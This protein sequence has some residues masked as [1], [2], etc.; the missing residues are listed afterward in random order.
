MILPVTALYLIAAAL[1]G[2][3]NWEMFRNGYKTTRAWENKYAKD[4]KGVLIPAPDK[5]Y[6][7][8]FRLQ[9]K[10]RFPLSATALVA[11][12]DRW[13]LYKTTSVFASRTALAL[14]IWPNILP[15]WWGLPIIWFALTAL[16]AFGFHIFY[17]WI[18]PKKD[19]A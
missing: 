9:Y 16:W 6:Y 5:P 8:L 18:K 3:E 17:T 7:R 4:T 13:H 10:E 14:L 19:E 1:N 12:T 15:A 2:L 11:L